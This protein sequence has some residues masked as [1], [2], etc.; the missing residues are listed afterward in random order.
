[1]ISGHTHTATGSLRFL[2]NLWLRSSKIYRSTLS[3]KQETGQNEIL[4]FSCLALETFKGCVDPLSFLGLQTSKGNVGFYNK[5]LSFVPR[6][7]STEHAERL[8]V[9]NLAHCHLVD[10]LSKTETFKNDQFNKLTCMSLL[11]HTCELK[12][13]AILI[14]AGLLYCIQAPCKQNKQWRHTLTSLKAMLT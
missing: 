4:T 2:L 14:D 9:A 1:M 5:V 3:P 11:L 12:V 8:D 6:R 10:I 7:K 13:W